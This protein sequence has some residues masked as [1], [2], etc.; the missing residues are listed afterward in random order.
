MGVC[1]RVGILS[2][3]GQATMKVVGPNGAGGT[4]GGDTIV[5][6]TAPVTLPELRA[7][8]DPEASRMLA[9]GLATFTALAAEH[10]AKLEA[11]FDKMVELYEQDRE[12]HLHPSVSVEAARIQVDVPAPVVS[13]SPAIAPIHVSAAP[14]MVSFTQAQQ[15]GVSQWLTLV[16]IELIAASMISVPLWLWYFQGK[17]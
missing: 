12:I 9:E 17:I 6:V 13:V 14:A 10:S 4:G 16:A 2:E 11:L 3:K 7:V 15:W 5:H 1:D 8:L